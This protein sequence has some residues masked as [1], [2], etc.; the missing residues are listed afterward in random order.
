MNKTVK[1][2]LAALGLAALIIIAVV[3]Y[4]SL[5][6]KYNDNG[7]DIVSGE[8]NIENSSDTQNS[9]SSTSQPVSRFPLAQDCTLLDK[10][11][12]EV[13]LSDFRGKP[14]VVNFWATW[15]G[16]CKEEMPDFNKSYL[17]HSDEVVYLMINVQETKEQAQAYIKENGFSFDVYYDT[18]GEAAAAFGVIAFPS[19]ILIN[20]EGGVIGKQMGLVSYEVLEEGV[21][22]LLDMAKE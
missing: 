9:Q 21:E 2:I 6:E 10:D 1:W 13:K 19:T 8:E 20:D 18:T 4:N 5:S 16:Y 3:L 11:G 17:N 22:I 15:C 12:K 7:F 14:I